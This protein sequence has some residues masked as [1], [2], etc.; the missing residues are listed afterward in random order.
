MDGVVIAAANPGLG[1]WAFIAIVL[2]T[3]L[4]WAVFTA[5]SRRAEIRDLIRH[6]DEVERWWDE[7]HPDEPCDGRRSA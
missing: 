1:L 5:R 2:A 4:V 6:E 7:R 3:W